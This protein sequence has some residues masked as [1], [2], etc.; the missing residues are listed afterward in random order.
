ELSLHPFRFHPSY[1]AIH[2]LPLADRVRAMRDPALRQ[3]ILA[4][5]P[6]HSN[7]LY[8]SLISQ[9]ANAFPLSDPPN[10]EPDPAD[11]LAAQASRKGMTAHEIAYDMLLED[12]GHALM[13]LPS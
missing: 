10:Y 1:V 7:P 13:L 9:F 12:D 2:H 3:R 11:S 4:E 8:L 5:Q 6:E